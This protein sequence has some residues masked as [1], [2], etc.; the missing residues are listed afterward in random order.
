MRPVT[1]LKLTWTTSLEERTT[2]NVHQVVIYDS[3][4]KANIKKKIIYIENV[5]KTSYDRMQ[6]VTGLVLTSVL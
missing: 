4:F 2:E 5:L 1:R 3:I 6:I